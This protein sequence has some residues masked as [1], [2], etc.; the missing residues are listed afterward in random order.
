MSRHDRTIALL[1]TINNLPALIATGKVKATFE[2]GALR[3]WTYSV[4]G[5]FPDA[6]STV[7][8]RKGNDIVART[9]TDF[10]RT[11]VKIP[12]WR[13]TSLCAKAHSLAYRTSR[14]YTGDASQG[15]RVHALPETLECAITM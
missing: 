7:F 4:D 8:E 12:T 15:K 3:I 11:Q 10:T 9:S 5:W 1:I 13:W 14:D 2:D 6:F